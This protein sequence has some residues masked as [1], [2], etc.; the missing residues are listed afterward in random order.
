[1]AR[2][3]PRPSSATETPNTSDCALVVTRSQLTTPVDAHASNF[4]DV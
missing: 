3:H 2:N 1:M 4:E